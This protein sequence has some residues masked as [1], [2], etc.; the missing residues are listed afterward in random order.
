MSVNRVIKFFI[1]S[2]LILWSGWGFTDPLFSVYV[3]QNVI[4]GSL[5]SIGYLAAIFW[6]TRAITQIPISLF[7]DKTDG[8]KDDFY[9]LIIGLLITGVSAFSLMA[10]TT[11]GQIYFIQFVKA[12]GFSLYIPA[13]AAIFTRHLDK[14]HSAFEWAVS[15]SSVGIGIGLAGFLG[16]LIANVDGFK[17]VFLITGLLAVISAC[18]LLF[19]PNLILPKKTGKSEIMGDHIRAGLK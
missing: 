13:W 11:V 3:V 19:V 1:I 16:S 7:L 14:T 9:A 6:A 15:S 10:A 18:V 8:E 2:D 12:I 17:L 4:G 5:L